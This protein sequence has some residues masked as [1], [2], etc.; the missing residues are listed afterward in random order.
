MVY[1]SCTPCGILLIQYLHSVNVY[2]TLDIYVYHS[3]GAYCG[4]TVDSVQ[5]VAA[6]NHRESMVINTGSAIISMVETP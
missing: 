2:I 6:Q 5:G 4:S 3:S 1:S